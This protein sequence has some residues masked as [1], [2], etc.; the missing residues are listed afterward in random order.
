M[1]AKFTASQ[2]NKVESNFDGVAPNDING[3]A[4][5][6]TTKLVSVSSDGQSYFDLI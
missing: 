4:L 6:L 3:Y 5:V 2:P 1:S